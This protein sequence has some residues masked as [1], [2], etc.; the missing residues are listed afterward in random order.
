MS[1]PRPDS[2][3]DFVRDGWA[4]FTTGIEEDVPLQTFVLEAAN[5]ELTVMV[6]PWGSQ[7][8]KYMALMQVALY[9]NKIDASRYA[10]FSE[11]WASTK[12]IDEKCAPSQASDRRSAVMAFGVDHTG[13]RFLQQAEITIDPDGSRHLG[14]PELQ[15]D[16]MSFEGDILQLFKAAERMRDPKII[17]AIQAGLRLAGSQAEE[18]PLHAEETRGQTQ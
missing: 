10:F 17:E 2:L 14:L 3:T 11:V 7:Q 12:A 15:P 5:G 9:I 4:V 1:K 16:D 8:E 13:E 18:F 6:T